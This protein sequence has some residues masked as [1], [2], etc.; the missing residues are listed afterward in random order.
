M[1]TISIPDAREITLE[2]L[3]LDMNGTLA[4]D[5]V[6]LPGIAALLDQIKPLLAIHL[7][8]ADTH[9]GG[10]AAAAAWVFAFTRCRPGRAGRKSWLCCKNWARRALWPWAT[11]STTP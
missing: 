2:H 9:G 8:T 6:L 4:K 7:I 11:A 5:G 1:L 3:V 10:Q